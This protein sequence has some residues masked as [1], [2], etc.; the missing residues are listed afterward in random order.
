MKKAAAKTIQPTRM[1]SGP[2]PG[3]VLAG[4]SS[5]LL[6]GKSIQNAGGK[7]SQNTKETTTEGDHSQD[8]TK[9]IK[10][11][12]STTC[13]ICGAPHS[14]AAVPDDDASDGD[15]DTASTE[16]E[17]DHNSSDEEDAEETKMV[18]TTRGLNYS[19]EYL[20]TTTSIRFKRSKKGSTGWHRPTS[21]RGQN[22]N[23]ALESQII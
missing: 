13:D 11:E 10:S 19:K 9:S 3:D 16:S 1:Q 8:D 2:A 17:N 20:T 18:C 22:Q 4:P 15:F 12:P 7:T 5:R 21:T 23:D 14:N 6:P